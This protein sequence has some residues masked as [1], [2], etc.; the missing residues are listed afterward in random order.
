MG[1]VAGRELRVVTAEK[2]LRVR[3]FTVNR[4]VYMVLVMRPLSASEDGRNVRFLDSF[5]LQGS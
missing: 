1:S 4:R 3:L 2:S 5:S